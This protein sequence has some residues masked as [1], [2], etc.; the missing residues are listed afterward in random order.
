MSN[1][2]NKIKKRRNYNLLD[3]FRR[4]V[5]VND[6]L[7]NTHLISVPGLATLTARSLASSDAQNL[8]GHAYWALDA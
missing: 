8:G 3:N 1:I 2:L 5:Q 6:S 7:V 4:T